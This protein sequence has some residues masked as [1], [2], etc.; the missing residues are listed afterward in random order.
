MELNNTQRIALEVSKII[1][2]IFENRVSS[3]KIYDVADDAGYHSFKIG[4]IA[5]NYFPVV[6]QYEQDI[7]G[8]YIEC[9]KNSCISLITDKC[10]Y[11]DTDIIL[12]L[13]CFVYHSLPDFPRSL[14]SLQCTRAFP[15]VFLP[16]AFH[17]L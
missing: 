16:Q 3:S 15:L 14:H 6:F 7:I 9:S 4:F 2:S 11:S 1:E 12:W 13:L 5:Y 10:C 8:C 17:L